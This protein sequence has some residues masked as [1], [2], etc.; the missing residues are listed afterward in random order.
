MLFVS[1]AGTGSAETCRDEER[2]KGERQTNRQRQKQT[3][4][5]RDREKQGTVGGG[6]G[7]GGGRGGVQLLSYATRAVYISG[8]W[9]LF[10]CL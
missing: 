10:I 9:C 5:D 3:D 8:V 2:E 4:Q 6:G 1:P 7:Y